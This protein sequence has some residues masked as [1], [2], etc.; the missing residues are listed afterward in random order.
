MNLLREKEL[1]R[2][3]EKKVLLQVLQNTKDT[4]SH[5]KGKFPYNCSKFLKNLK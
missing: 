2:I 3:S 4:N 1:Q 5:E